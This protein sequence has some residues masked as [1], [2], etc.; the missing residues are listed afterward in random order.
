M[1]CLYVPA[2]LLA[3]LLDMLT[4]GLVALASQLP[5]LFVCRTRFLLPHIR[6]LPRLRTVMYGGAPRG[7]T[8]A[9]IS[10]SPS[11]TAIFSPGLA[12]SGRSQAPSLR[13]ASASSFFA[14]VI[15]LWEFSNR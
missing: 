9:W 4:E 8:S 15:A 12:S 1:Y 13:V 3:H 6:G 5:E 10:Q 14:A 11:Q 2:L 7:A